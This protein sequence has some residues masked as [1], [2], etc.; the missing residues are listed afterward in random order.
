MVVDPFAS[1]RGSLSPQTS[2]GNMG[3]GDGAGSATVTSTWLRKKGSRL[4]RENH[5]V[6]GV[7]G[8]SPAD[9]ERWL[10]MSPIRMT[11]DAAVS[12]RADADLADFDPVNKP[13]ND[14]LSIVEPIEPFAA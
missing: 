6:S 4:I 8:F 3:K 12:R 5:G 10:A 9:Y 2:H 13:E 11:L 1:L 14:D 7:E